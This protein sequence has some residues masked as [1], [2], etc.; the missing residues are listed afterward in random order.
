MLDTCLPQPTPCPFQAQSPPGLQAGR[1]RTPQRGQ[2]L[3]MFSCDRLAALRTSK[4]PAIHHS[5]RPLPRTFVA[6][7]PVWFGHRQSR[8]SVEVLASR[9]LPRRPPSMGLPSPASWEA[10]SWGAGTLSSP[11]ECENF[12]KEDQKLTGIQ[13][14]RPWRGSRRG[15]SL[16]DMGGRRPADSQIPEALTP[17]A[18]TRRGLVLRR[19]Q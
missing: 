5:G 11:E 2:S 16:R 17:S 1:A 14:V 3:G 7:A 8:G 6:L 19:A 10:L 9:G 12:Q 13:G 4:E 15:K 18:S